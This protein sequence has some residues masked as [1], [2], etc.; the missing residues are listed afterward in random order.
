M[1]EEEWFKVEIYVG[2]LS[3]GTSEDGL[4]ELFANHGSVRQVKNY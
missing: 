1:G 2:N 4:N 3:Y